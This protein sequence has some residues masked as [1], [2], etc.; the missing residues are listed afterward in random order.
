MHQELMNQTMLLS[1]SFWLKTVLI[2][3]EEDRWKPNDE[4]T[5]KNMVQG[6][7]AFLV[8]LAVQHTSKIDSHHMSEVQFQKHTHWI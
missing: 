2:L 6:T 5:T 1:V 8:G 7:T 4:N 3:I